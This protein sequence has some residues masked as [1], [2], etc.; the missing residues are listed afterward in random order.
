[1]NRYIDIYKGIRPTTDN[2]LNSSLIGII[3]Q[4]HPVGELRYGFFQKG[5]ENHR[6]YDMSGWCHRLSGWRQLPA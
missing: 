5:M 1:M 4:P 2:R 3:T 6:F